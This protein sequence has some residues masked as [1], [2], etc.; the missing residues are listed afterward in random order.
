MIAL[1]WLVSG[2]PSGILPHYLR[3]LPTYLAR[4]PSGPFKGP[5]NPLLPA[6]NDI[7]GGKY[8]H[9]HMYYWY[10]TSG[11]PKFVCFFS[12]AYAS[13][14][15]LAAL[16]FFS[17]HLS[18]TQLVS[19]F[20]TCSLIDFNGSGLCFNHT[21]IADDYLLEGTSPRSARPKPSVISKQRGF[22]FFLLFCLRG[23]P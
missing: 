13:L 5:L 2:T 12:V 22:F 7:A 6:V 8:R 14:A 9:I 17:P 4:I 23:I 3:Y 1:D 11:S 21:Y 20:F 19:R 18:T 10:W 15:S 16:A